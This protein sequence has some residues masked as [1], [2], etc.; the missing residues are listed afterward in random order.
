MTPVNLNKETRQHLRSDRKNFRVKTEIPCEV[1]P[2]GGEMKVALIRDLSCGGV[3]FSCNH[4][5][6]D[7]I[8]PDDQTPLGV[9]LDAYINIHFNLSADNSHDTTIKTGAKLVHTERLAQDLF[10]V[11]VEFI[12]LPREATGKL[13]A[14]IKASRKE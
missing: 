10:Q 1:G 9:V 6:I 12:D 11:G 4:S 14:F 7:N 3:K 2:A 5:V 13:E 8:F